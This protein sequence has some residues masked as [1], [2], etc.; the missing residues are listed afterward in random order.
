M[1]APA[2]TRLPPFLKTAYGA[3]ALSENILNSVLNQFANA[4]YTIT[5][6]LNP[7]LVGVG[8]AI[9]RL[10]DAVFDLVV[11]SYSDNLRTR[12]GR[13]KPLMLAGLLSSAL[14]LFLLFLAPPEW[15]DTAKFVY[16]LLG[17]VLFYTCSTLY[18]VPYLAM[19]YELTSDYD[20]RSRLMGYRA[21]F[22]PMGL[23]IVPWLFAWA[24]SPI[25]SD[26]A[27]GARVV[28]AG[29][30]VLVLLVGLVPILLVPRAPAHAGGPQ[31]KIPIRQAIQ[32]TLCNRTFLYALLPCLLVA[33]SLNLNGQIFVIATIYHVY[34]GDVAL[35]S[36][37]AASFITVGQVVGMIGAPV[38]ARLAVRF[39]KKE[40]MRVLLSVMAFVFLSSLWLITPDAPWLAA[41]FQL[42]LCPVS[43]GIF[44]L[45]HSM[46]ADVCDEDE[47]RTGARR[48]AT[49]AAVAGW[50]YKTGS[51][52]AIVVSGMVLWWAGFEADRED[53]QCRETLTTLRLI[54]AVA[55]VFAVAGGLFLLR[56]Y[57]LSRAALSRIHG[58][59]T[60]RQRQSRS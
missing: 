1:P 46:V 44:L 8:L 54:Y 17:G 29:V 41:V 38:V 43:A 2:P 19:G 12:W 33:I 56:K 35:G 21:F 51:S 5:F 16:F 58:E 50:I 39:G 52:A 28:S 32:L 31:P 6:A 9:P 59:L 23:L 37:M 27:N 55:P 34:G 60:Q 11:G 13:R 36:M 26:A 3:G 24:H 15:S 42:F 47:L 53:G 14:A 30:G 22:A 40:T 20:E 57:P 10:W 4:V 45:Y 18:C 49:Y 48:E 7:A 25:F